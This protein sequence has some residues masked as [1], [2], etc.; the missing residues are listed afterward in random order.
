M[1]DE[2]A[3]VNVTTDEKRRRGRRP[4]DARQRRAAV[5]QAIAELESA[6]VPFTMSDVAERAGISRATLYRDAGLRDLVGARGDSPEA[7]PV[8]ARDLSRLEKRIAS[9]E[10]ERKRLRRELRDTEERL[11]AAEIDAEE[12]TERARQQARARRDETID[13]EFVEKVRKESYADGF[14]AGS[15][16]AGARGGGRGGAS[17]LVSVAARLPR[18][19]VLNA[20]RTLAKALHPDL[21]AQDPAAALLATELLKQ[22][23]ALAGPGR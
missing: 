8:T 6:R 14:A 18:A 5:E 19:S 15:R 3:T 23:N 13:N 1:R 16:A 22:L 4:A 20:R 12:A 10:E 9:L 17:D 21:Y 11:K 2:S 7:R